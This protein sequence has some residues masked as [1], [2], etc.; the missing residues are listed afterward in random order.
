MWQVQGRDSFLDMLLVCGLIE[1]RS[2]EPFR[3]LADT[4][5]GTELGHFYEDL[6]ASE[7]NHYL[8]FT[9]LGVD[10]FGE[11]LT[12]R[13]LNEMRA[14]EAQLIQSLRERRRRCE[15]VDGVLIDKALPDEDDPP[16]R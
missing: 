8:L 6:Y 15:L 10:F 13:R 16:A 4:A 2:A 11:E 7:V 3:L 12:M 9:N 5:H 14:V 1:A